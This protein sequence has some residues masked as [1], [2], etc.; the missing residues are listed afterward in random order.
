MNLTM[1]TRLSGPSVRSIVSPGKVRAQELT[2]D[3]VQAMRMMHMISFAGALIFLCKPAQPS[4]TC[5]GHVSS[6]R[7]MVESNPYIT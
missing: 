3:I 1:W 7:L 4:A 6:S 5:I 2:L